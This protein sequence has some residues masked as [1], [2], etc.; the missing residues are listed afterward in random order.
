MFSSIRD[1]GHF[2]RAERR[3]RI[4]VCCAAFAETTRLPELSEGPP[5]LRRQITPFDDVFRSGYKNKNA[6]LR[7]IRKHSR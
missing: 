2:S 7:G 3:G 4:T 1:V 5:S 6:E